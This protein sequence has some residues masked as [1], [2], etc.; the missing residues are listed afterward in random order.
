MLSPG[1]IGVMSTR[2]HHEATQ[3]QQLV[4]GPNVFRRS[5]DLYWFPWGK[6]LGLLCTPTVAIEIFFHIR[7]GSGAGLSMEQQGQG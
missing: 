3:G 5:R 4:F 1:L 2:L 7:E 6:G